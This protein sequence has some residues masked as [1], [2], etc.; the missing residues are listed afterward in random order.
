MAVCEWV[1]ELL[2]VELWATNN[3]DGLISM[4]EDFCCYCLFICFGIFGLFVCVCV[5][6]C[7]RASECVSFRF[8]LAIQSMIF[9]RVIYTRNHWLLPLRTS[10]K[11]RAWGH[12]THTLTL[13]AHGSPIYQLHVCMFVCSRI[14]LL[15]FSFWFVDLKFEPR[16]GLLLRPYL[17][18]YN[19]VSNLYA[20]LFVWSIS[21]DWNDL[22]I[23][24]KILIS[25]TRNAATGSF[26][27]RERLDDGRWCSIESH[28]N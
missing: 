17:Y 20:W 13:L 2:F 27:F 28:T 14:V 9:L 1:S 4:D 5:C 11:N 22:F 8:D 15:F 6:V 23:Y 12:S 25:G 21:R 26:N 7:A 3:T 18:L 10:D 19:I 16:G 24:F